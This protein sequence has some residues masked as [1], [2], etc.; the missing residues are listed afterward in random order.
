MMKRNINE[1]AAADYR[2]NCI[3]SE[4]RKKAKMKKEKEMQAIY[5]NAP[6]AFEACRFDRIMNPNK[7]FKP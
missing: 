5:E 6:Y 7:W 2:L 1:V 3:K 4:K